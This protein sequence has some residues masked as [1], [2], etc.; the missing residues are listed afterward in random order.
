[1]GAIGSFY[2]LWGPT[3]KAALLSFKQGNYA[4]AKDFMLEFQKTIMYVLPNIWTFLRQA[5]QLKYGIDIGQTK[6]PLGTG[7]KSWDN[8]EVQSILDKIESM[9][10]LLVA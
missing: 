5:M 3:C 7:Q 6:A 1:S 9:A 4:F 10:N 2:N 8:R